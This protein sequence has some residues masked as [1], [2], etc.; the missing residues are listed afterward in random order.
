L[1]KSDERKKRL[2][3]ALRENL[4]RRKARSRALADVG[5]PGASDLPPEGRNPAPQ[6]GK[7]EPQ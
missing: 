4:K 3:A 7:T 5:V 1:G 6:T 2:E